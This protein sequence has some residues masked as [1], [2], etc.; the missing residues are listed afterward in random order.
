MIHNERELL[1]R[2]LSGEAT[3]EEA[4]RLEAWLA[5]DPERWSELAGLDQERADA[6]LGRAA[7]ERAAAG[8]W[9]RLRKDVGDEAELVELRHVRQPRG[10]PR[11]SSSLASSRWTTGLQVAAALVIVAGAGTAM[12]M[13]VRSRQAASVPAMRVATTGAGERATFRLSDG[14]SVMLGVASTLRYPVSFGEGSREVQVEGEAYFDVGRDERRP[15]VV[16]AGQLVATDLGTQFTVRL[17]PEDV[18][19]RVVVREGRVAIRA[20]ADGA[21]ELVVSAGQL[22]RLQGGGS[23]SIEAAAIGEYFAWIEGRLVLDKVPLRQALPELERWFDLEFRLGDSTIADAQ[24]TATLKTQPTP[25]VL[26][27]L[28]ASLGLRARKVGRL[29]TLYP[30]EPNPTQ[31]AASLSQQRVNHAASSHCLDVAQY[32]RPVSDRGF[33]GGW[34]AEPA[35]RAAAVPLGRLE[36]GARVRR[37]RR[38]GAAASSDP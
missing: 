31:R 26:N 8:V 18:G 33:K 24:L 2:Y 14:T 7:V 3:P 25:D 15:F 4:A 27:N 32:D 11:L 37:E 38:A 21:P 35:H 22:G 6:A 30:A 23:L 1:R 10:T 9:A 29:V 36:A 28:A 5:E 19:P 34:P 20:Q 17:Y 12:G 13:W 16:R